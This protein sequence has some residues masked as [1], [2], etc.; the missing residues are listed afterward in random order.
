MRPPLTASAFLAAQEGC[1]CS[2]CSAALPPTRCFLSVG[3]PGSAAAGNG[4]GAPGLPAVPAGLPGPLPGGPR[5]LPGPCPPGCPL[6][7]CCEPGLL[8]CTWICSCPKCSILQPKVWRQTANISCMTLI[9]LPIDRTD[10]VKLQ[11]V[12]R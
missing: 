1:S 9:T 3:R 10:A 7:R 2:G 12:S 6:G 4:L 11:S 5:G 8:W